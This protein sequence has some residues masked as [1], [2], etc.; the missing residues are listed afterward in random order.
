M[1]APAVIRK[2]FTTAE[3]EQIAAA[4]IFGE[5]ER[6]ELL[7]GE[8]V[9]MSPLGPQHSATVTR[10]TELFYELGNPS[11]TIRVQD[12]IR[13][14]DYSVPQPDVAIVN[15]RGDR[16]AGGHPEPEDVLLLIE[17][18]E[19]SLAYDRDVKLP[20]YARAGIAEVWLVALLPQVVEVYRAPND[21]GYGEKR[22]LRRGDTLAPL[23]LPGAKLA[24]EPILS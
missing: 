16:Y 13:L 17:V 1:E 4:G 20:L 5:D 14:G 6:F 15:R 8:I 22:T 23:H 10:L 11:I 12:P 2:R 7:E 19:S 3:F 24:I 18:S 21:N 9:A